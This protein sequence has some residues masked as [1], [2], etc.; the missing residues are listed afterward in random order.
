MNKFKEFKRTQIAEMRE[1]TDSDILQK[2]SS[3][4]LVGNM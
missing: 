1:V 4:Y 2:I 3:V